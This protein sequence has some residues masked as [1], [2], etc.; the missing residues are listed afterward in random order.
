MNAPTRIQVLSVEDVEDDTRLLELE[1]RRGGFSPIMRRVDTADAMR[2]ALGEVP[3]DIVLSDY[4]MPS[5]GALEAL[6]V[7]KESG[8][9]IP[10]IIVSGSIGE[11]T[12]VE[13]LKAGAHDFV[14][15]QNLSRFV[16]AVS[17][18]I[19]EARMR[20]ERALAL[21]ALKE[22]EARHIRL[23]EEVQDALRARDEFL[24]VASH[25]LKT[26]LT[27]LRLEAQNLQRNLARGN[28]D[29]GR[30]ATRVESMVIQ[31]T[32]LTKLINNLLE[33][34]H[35]TATTG[36]PALMRESL[37]LSE[38]IRDV[39]GRFATEL[40]SSECPLRLQLQEDVAG[41]WDRLRMESVLVNLI[42]NA[43]KYGPR[44]PITL[45]LEAKDGVVRLSVRDE[46]I[47][48]APTDQA[49]IFERFE[50]AVSIRHYGGLGIGLWLVR[51][52]VEAHGGRIEVRSA[53]EEG[54]T[55]TMEL[56]QQAPGS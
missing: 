48:I 8:L 2:R 23:L 52:I 36:Q 20:R 4:S 42:G 18:E 53:P 54:S 34:T 21:A 35:L 3:W 51:R 15:K 45:S 22:S 5:F 32:R 31:I 44:K 29:V 19:N 38:L 47:G 12:A 40:E 1:L 27:S 17:R 10:F 28:V 39:C 25:E 46:G 30:A 26:P 14:V 24:T 49:R 16:P 13:A 9:D 7:L 50:R 11:E 55:F 43:I 6:R 56:P 37:N 33:V 41:S